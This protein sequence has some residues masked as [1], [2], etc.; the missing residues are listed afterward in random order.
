MWVFLCGWFRMEVMDHTQA[1][2]QIWKPEWTQRDIKC[3]SQK[4]QHWCEL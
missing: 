4:L 1:D 3:T 2:Q